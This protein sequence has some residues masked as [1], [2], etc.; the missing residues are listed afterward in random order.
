M[1][2]KAMSIIGDRFGRLIVTA[3]AEGNGR[4]S[5]WH[6]RC[7]CG[8]TRIAVG[9]ELRNGY[10]KSCG[11]LR[12]DTAKAAAAQSARVRKGQPSKKRGW[13]RMK[14]L[15]RVTY[16]PVTPAKEWRGANEAGAELY[17]LWRM[18]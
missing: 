5:R 10:V 6:C 9:S 12:R 16:T 2:R 1:G 8:G 11:C 17:K 7:D 13:A 14:E 15:G 3:Q 18:P 4:Q